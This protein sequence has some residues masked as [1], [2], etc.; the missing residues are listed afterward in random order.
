MMM[1]ALEEHVTLQQVHDTAVF[2]FWTAGA[3]VSTATLVAALTGLLTLT[4][5]VAPGITARCTTALRE[6]NFLSFFVGAPTFAAFGVLALIGTKA[7]IIGFAA[8]AGFTVLALVGLASASEDVGR[9]LAWVCG[10]EGSRARHLATGWLVIAAASCVPVIGWF[11]VLPYSILS[12][13]GSF[14]VGA[15]SRGAAAASPRE[16]VDIEIR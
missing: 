14:L 11:I 1:L 7:P 3:L 10:K 6:H 15:F 12:G 8:V 5:V 13:L 4:M 2:F 9:R 16:P